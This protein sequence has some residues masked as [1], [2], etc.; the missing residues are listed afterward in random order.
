MH[1]FPCSHMT[2]ACVVWGH[3]F[4]AKLQLHTTAVG[5]CGRLSM[6][7]ASALCWAIRAPSL[8]CL[9]VLFVICNILMLHGIIVKQIVHYFYGLEHSLKQASPA[10]ATEIGNCIHRQLHPDPRWAAM[11]LYSAT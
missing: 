8:M 10:G 3:A 2:F 11:L 6:L 5:G 1:S 4:G 9:S 7:F